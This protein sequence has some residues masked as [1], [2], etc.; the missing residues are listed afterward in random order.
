MDIE[1]AK[2]WHDKTTTVSVIMGALG[3]IKKRSNKHIN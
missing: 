3:M 2:M 1:T